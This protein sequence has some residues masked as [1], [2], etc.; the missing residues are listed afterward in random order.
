MLTGGPGSNKSSLCQKVV[1]QAPGWVHLSLGRLLRAAAEADQAETD[2]SEGIRQAVSVG[3]MV[4]RV[5]TIVSLHYL[6]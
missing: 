3:E 5:S 4:D 6:Q 1:R 2:D